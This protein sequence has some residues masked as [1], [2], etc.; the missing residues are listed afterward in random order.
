MD[1]LLTMEVAEDDQL[2]TGDLQASAVDALESGKVIFLPRRRFEIGPDE[3]DLLNPSVVGDAKNVSYNPQTGTI[4]GTTLVGDRAEALRKMMG[5]FSAEQLATLRALIPGYDGGVVQGRSSFRPV[6]IAGRPSSWRKDDTRLH[7]DSFPSSPT[8]GKRIL[9]MFVNINPD[10]KGRLWRLG[11][12]FEN[13][14]QR[15]LPATRRPFPGHATALHLFRVTK[16]RRSEYDHLM[17]QFH[18]LMKGDEKYQREVDQMDHE[19]PPG[20]TWIAY[21]D[22]VSHAVTR[23][24]YQLE[25]T[26]L[27]SVPNQRTPERSPLRV[28]E[29]LTGRKLA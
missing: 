10:G 12:P 20:S 3:R 16:T 9:R 23:G 17:L 4:G 22:Q 19:F 27:V 11:E 21:A 7:V 24:Q 26:F 25:Q 28:L 18:D 14:A 13:M 1:R 15:F 2:R 5:S 6:E 29:R 8:Q